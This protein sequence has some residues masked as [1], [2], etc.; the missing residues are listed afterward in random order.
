M[1]V[2]WSSTAAVLIALPWTA[3]AV[4]L[5]AL[6]VTLLAAGVKHHAARTGRART[7]DGAAP[8]RAG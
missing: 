6:A 2:G 7:C 1:V 4:A 3:A 8:G 5:V